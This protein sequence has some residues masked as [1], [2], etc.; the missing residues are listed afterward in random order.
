MIAPRAAR[1]ALHSAQPFNRSDKHPTFARHFCVTHNT[2]NS[3]A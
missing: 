1:C 2:Y 3:A